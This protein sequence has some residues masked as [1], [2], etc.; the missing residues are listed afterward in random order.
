MEEEVFLSHIS[1][2]TLTFSEETHKSTCAKTCLPNLPTGVVKMIQRETT[3]GSAEHES[4]E[5]I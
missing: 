2:F 3:A 4:V 5:I 1:C